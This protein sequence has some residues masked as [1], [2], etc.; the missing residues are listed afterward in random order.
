[1]DGA[2]ASS[3]AACAHLLI[4]LGVASIHAL[5]RI[6]GRQRTSLRGGC[7]RIGSMK[8]LLANEATGE[9]DRSRSPS[10]G[11]CGHARFRCRR[12]CHRICHATRARRSKKTLRN[13]FLIELG[14]RPRTHVRCSVEL[15]STLVT[16]TAMWRAAMAQ[17]CAHGA[18]IFTSESSD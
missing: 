5:V 16:D 3:R 13:N 9:I 11:Q 6:V 2:L 17:S 4:G 8:E 12:S 1:M 18:Q 15:G 7:F 10:R 14:T